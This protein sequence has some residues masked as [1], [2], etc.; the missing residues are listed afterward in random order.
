MS[1]TIREL[2]MEYFKSHPYEDIEHGPVVDWV[3]NE[4]IKTH[5]N[6]PR[7]PWR[8]IR[9]LH[10]HGFLQKVST[11]IYRY[12]PSLVV[13]KE[14]EDFTSEQREEIFR[15]DGYKCVICGRG[16]DSGYEIHA[17]HIKPKSLGG[18]SDI[19]NG[20]TLC[21]IH[22]LRKKNLGQ[23]ETGKKM[24][25]H[26]YEL[27]MQ[28]KDDELLSFCKNILEVYEEHNM[29]DHVKWIR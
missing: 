15:R 2:V 28:S 14:L 23:T 17:D 11:G 4:W 22:N 1:E 18:K 27:A 16:R 5:K 20:Q 8:T 7:D 3:T 29:N 19:S 13:D 10:E 9:S 6:P 26:L 24:F 12:E 25:I 21:S